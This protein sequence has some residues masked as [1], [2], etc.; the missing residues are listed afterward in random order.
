[1]AIRTIE[2]VL[3]ARAIWHRFAAPVTASIWMN[4][5]SLESDFGKYF[6]HRQREFSG[7]GRFSPVCQGGGTRANLRQA[8]LEKW[9][10]I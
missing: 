5:A 8:G 1:M 7:H 2:V 3:Q 9:I 10:T 4:L 6:L